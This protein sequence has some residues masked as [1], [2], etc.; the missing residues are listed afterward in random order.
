M[1]EPARILQI[2]GFFN[3]HKKETQPI[4]CVS[5]YVITLP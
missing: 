3:A 4:G 2:C 5:L 1:T